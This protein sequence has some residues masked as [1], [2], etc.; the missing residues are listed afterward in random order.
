MSRLGYEVSEL[1]ALAARGHICNVSKLY[2]HFRRTSKR[3]HELKD[4]LCN[5]RIPQRRSTCVSDDIIY[6]CHYCWRG[7]LLPLESYKLSNAASCLHF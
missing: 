4:I 3:E 7:M 2:H 1:I 5:V 6:E